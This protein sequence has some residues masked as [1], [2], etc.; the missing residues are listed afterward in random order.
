MFAY[1]LGKP[2]GYVLFAMR[3]LW[4]RHMVVPTHRALLI[5]AMHTMNNDDDDEH[6]A[7]YD[8]DWRRWLTMMTDEDDDDDDDNDDDES[9]NLI[10][11][12]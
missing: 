6:K 4:G 7:D 8:Y 10:S 12:D 5:D 11:I 9:G 2:T 3:W 1:I